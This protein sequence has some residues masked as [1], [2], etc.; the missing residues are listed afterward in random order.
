MEP[1]AQ[2]KYD[3]FINRDVGKEFTEVR[4]MR[5]SPHTEIIIADYRALQYTYL[6]SYGYNFV[7]WIN[8]DFFGD[9][10]YDASDIQDAID[11]VK[12]RLGIEIEWNELLQASY[13]KYVY[14]NYNSKEELRAAFDLVNDEAE[15]GYHVQM[16]VNGVL[17]THN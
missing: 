4:V 9:D 5:E 8:F 7:L 17:L 6:R 12:N 1:D 16:I 13:G 11:A 15:F 14:F 10:Y 2:A 3:A